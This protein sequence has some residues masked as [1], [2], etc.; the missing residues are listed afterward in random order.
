MTRSAGSAI[1]SVV[2]DFGQAAGQDVLEE[3]FDKLR[4]RNPYPF[5]LLGSVVP[6]AKGYLA[7]LQTLQAGVA[8]GNVE[9]VTTQIIEHLLATAGV[10][11]MDH[12]FLAPSL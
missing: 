5:D 9:D 12:P 2:P 10:L 1:Q 4:R 6:I 3:A 11:S 8:Y 7:F